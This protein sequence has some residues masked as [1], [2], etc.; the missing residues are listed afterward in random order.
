MISLDEARHREPCSSFFLPAV[1]SRAWLAVY[2]AEL[3]LFAEGRLLGDE[4]LQ[5]AEVVDHPGSLLVASWGSGMLS[6]RQGNLPKAVP[7]LERAVD[8]CRDMNLPCL[9]PRAAAALGTA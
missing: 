5:T 3:G 4:G 6:L 7:L 9:F 2:H 1:H 8:L